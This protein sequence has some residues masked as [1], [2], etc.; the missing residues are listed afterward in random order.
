MKRMAALSLVLAAGC[1]GDAG[2][3]VVVDPVRL[4]DEEVARATVGCLAAYDF[5]RAFNVVLPGGLCG[6]TPLLGENE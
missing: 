2:D 5:A 4:P 6:L 3:P 1:V